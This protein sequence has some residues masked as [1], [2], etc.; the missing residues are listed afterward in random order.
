M[1]GQTLKKITQSL[2]GLVLISVLLIPA[3]KI[4]TG[5]PTFQ[6]IDFLLPFVFGVLYLRRK[7]I[8]HQKLYAIIGVFSIYVLFTMFYNGRLNQI[9]DY[10][11][12]YKLIKFLSV[13]LLFSLIDTVRFLQFWIKPVF[14]VLVIGNLFHYFNLFNFNYIIEHYY[15]GGIHIQSFGVNSLGLPTYKRMLGFAGNPNINAIIF[16]IFA[17]LFFPKNKPISKSIGWFLVA[18]FMLF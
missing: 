12:I 13:I 11:E 17:I 14:I 8:T 7:E 10:F 6:L 18:V 5:F 2:A 3:I 1:T 15:N 16:A 4:K 9:R